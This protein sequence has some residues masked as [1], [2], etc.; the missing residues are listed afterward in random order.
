MSEPMIAA[1][2]AGSKSGFCESATRH[3]INY[4]PVM[5]GIIIDN[6]RS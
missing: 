6:S 4:M 3:Q 5:T 1:R 2:T